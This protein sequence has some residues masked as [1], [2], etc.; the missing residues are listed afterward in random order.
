MT[1]SPDRH[2]TLSTGISDL[3]ARLEPDLPYRLDQDPAAHLDLVRVAR[4]ISAAVDEVERDAVRAA[5]SA[6]VSWEAIGGVL[7]VSRQAAHQRYGLP[8]APATGTTWRMTPVT[9]F[10]EMERLAEAG[11]RGWHSVGFGALYHD[12][13]R[14][15]V[16]W[17][18]LRVTAFQRHR[19]RELLAEGW[20]RI[21]SMWFP[22]A[23]YARPT[24][25]PAEE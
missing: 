9:A 10:D 18:H 12:L 15:E 5:R 17:E 22:W 23:Y 1:D 19:H 13:E 3:I 7:G 4:E 2:D 8:E 6:G 25:L 16:Q 20:Q 14:S 21:G 11:R 24:R